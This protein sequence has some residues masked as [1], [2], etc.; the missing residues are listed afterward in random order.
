MVVKG[1]GKRMSEKA[2][3]DCLCVRLAVC[4]LN[5]ESIDRVSDELV[6]NEVTTNCLNN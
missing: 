6:S 4:L 1:E 2:S 3:K 5:R